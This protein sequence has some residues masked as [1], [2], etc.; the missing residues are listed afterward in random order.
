MTRVTKL[1]HAGGRPR[2]HADNAAR[3]KAYRDR[4][5]VRLRNLPWK[6]AKTYRDAPHAY[7]ILSQNTAE[8]FQY[9]RD[10]IKSE[11][12][13]EK[14]TLRGRTHRYRYYHAGDG[15]KYWI[16]GAVLNRAQAARPQ[17]GKEI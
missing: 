2:V 17:E 8:A 15:F 10:K 12:V 16:I 7:V 9:F 11:G 1:K 13:A 14:F 3:Q 6:N 5:R 4:T